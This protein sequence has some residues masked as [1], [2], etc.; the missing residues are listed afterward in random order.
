MCVILSLIAGLWSFL[1]SAVY[2][3][4][5]IPPALWA[6]AIGACVT[7]SI[8]LITR[9]Q[10]RRQVTLDLHKEFYSHAFAEQRG[11]ATRFFRRYATTDWSRLSPGNL[12]DPDDNHQGYSEVLRFW[13]RVAVLYENGA[14][15]RSLAQRLL[16]RELGYWF[17]FVFE[18]MRERPDMFTRELLFG[19]SYQFET[20]EGKGLYLAGLQSGREHRPVASR[21]KWTHNG[22]RWVTDPR[23][24]PA[25][26]NKPKKLRPPR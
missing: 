12:P 2:F 3:F 4:G 21:A 23:R 15:D 9:Q 1:C 26:P 8:F 7:V 17:G 20:G 6:A 11:K 5:H 18:D 14:L 24:R 13:H 10:S 16:S 19:L 22:T 25:S